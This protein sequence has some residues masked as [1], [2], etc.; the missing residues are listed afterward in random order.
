MQRTVIQ[1]TQSKKDFGIKKNDGANLKRNYSSYVYKGKK[2][3]FSKS[4]KIKSKIF[5]NK[6]R[7]IIKFK[8]IVPLYVFEEAWS[9]INKNLK[10]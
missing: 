6:T 1:T 8:R 2:S 7:K 5:K 9:F 3:N 4:L 10:G